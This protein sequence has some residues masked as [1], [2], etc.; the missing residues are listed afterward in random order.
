MKKLIIILI[1]FLAF[2]RGVSAHLPGQPA[3]FKVNGIYA[4][5]YHVPST[6]LS[7]FSLPQDQGPTNYVKNEPIEFEV[8]TGRLGIAEDVKDTLKL[9][10]DYGDGTK[11]QGRITN[12]IYKKIGS[13]M[14]TV[15]ADDG[16]APTP[17]LLESVRINILPDKDY[18]L[19]T[20]IITINDKQSKDP[21]SDVLNIDLRNEVTFDS[22]KSIITGEA[23]SYTWDF[24]DGRSA[25]GKEQK[26]RYKN[27]LKMVFPVLRIIDKNGFI[28][29][30]YVQITNKPSSQSTASTSAKSFDFSK[31]LPYF[32]GVL[33]AL[34]GAMIFL[35]VKKRR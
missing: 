18:K 21:L 11:S 7:D 27:D 26:H 24:G 29:D 15:H 23:S 22:S 19:P 34:L 9:Y 17:Q 8:D 6:S 30:A 14:L 35:G 20:A 4:N 31:V 32:L 10:W 28:A 13:Y 12:H 3:F 5:Y 16:Q 2:P 1:F 25:T 33:V